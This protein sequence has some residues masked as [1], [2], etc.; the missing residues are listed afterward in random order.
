MPPDEVQ[1]STVA[2]VILS[3]LRNPLSGSRPGEIPFTII[4]VMAN[5]GYAGPFHTTDYMKRFPEVYPKFRLALTSLARE[6]VIEMSEMPKPDTHHETLNYYI[7]KDETGPNRQAKLS[8]IAS[9]A[10]G[11]NPRYKM[12][13]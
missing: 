8:E 12:A 4:D 1:D 13:T 11:I 6:G 3:S 10:Q 2:Y 9:Q 7:P 5:A